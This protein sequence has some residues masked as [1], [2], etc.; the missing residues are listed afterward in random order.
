MVNPA[1]DHDLFEAAGLD[2]EALMVP[3]SPEG[4]G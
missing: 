1:P 4:H 2:A 3:V